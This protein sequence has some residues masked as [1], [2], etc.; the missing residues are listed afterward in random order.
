MIQK[1]QILFVCL[2]VAGTV[3]ATSP[4]VRGEIR[5]AVK[6]GGRSQV[7]RYCY[8]GNQ[9]RIDRPGEII[10]SPPVN[11]LDLEKGTLSILYP[12]NGTWEVGAEAG[13]QRLEVGGQRS[14][15]GDQGSEVGSQSSVVAPRMAQ[16]ADW[17]KTPAP[18]GGLPEGV[19]PASSKTPPSSFNPGTSMGMPAFPEMPTFPMPGAGGEKSMTL[20]SQGQ[21]NELFGFSCCLYNVVIP[22]KGTVELWLCDNPGLPPFHLLAYRLQDRRDRSEWDKQLAQRLRNEKKFPFRMVLKSE[23]GGDVLA[24]WDVVSIKTD[25]KEKD[26]DGVFDVPSEMHRLPSREW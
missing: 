15:A 5:M 8:A 25:L 3:S 21:T 9:L 2:C 23:E 13:D 19:G 22:R 24:E 14:R 6:N 7:L 17:P 4:S 16:P 26:V 11:L 1:N 12:H 10:P 20:V 18:P